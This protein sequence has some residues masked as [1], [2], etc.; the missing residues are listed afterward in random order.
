M[1]NYT[2]KAFNIDY[3]E[4]L[5]YFKLTKDE[6]FWCKCWLQGLQTTKSS[7]LSQDFLSDLLNMFINPIDR[8][9]SI[10]YEE[11]NKDDLLD[12]KIPRILL[13][14]FVYGIGRVAYCFDVKPPTS[15]IAQKILN[16]IHRQIESQLPFNDNWFKYNF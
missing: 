3:Y 6:F 13:K 15:V 2:Q 1:E 9:G 14:T 8:I 5:I 4:K 7:H 11:Y 16:K 12:I 10:S